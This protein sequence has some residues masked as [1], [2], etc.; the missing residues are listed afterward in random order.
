MVNNAK[1]RGVHIVDEDQMKSFINVVSHVLAN[2][3]VLNTIMT[4]VRAWGAWDNEAKK[5][6]T[7]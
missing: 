3:E 1:V 4:L 5:I 2:P 6:P 7:R